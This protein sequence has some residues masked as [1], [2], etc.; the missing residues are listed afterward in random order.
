MSNEKLFRSCAAQ[1]AAQIIRHANTRKRT[2]PFHHVQTKLRV[3][4][5]VERTM[6]HLCIALA[7]GLAL[8]A[9]AIHA[10]VMATIGPVTAD[11]VGLPPQPPFITLLGMANPGK[12]VTDPSIPPK[13]AVRE[14]FHEELRAI[15][16][17][18]GPAG[19]VEASVRTKYDE[20]GRVIERI[21]NRFGNETDDVYRYQGDRVVGIETTCPDAKKPQ[22][23]AWNYWTWDS[24]GKLTEYRRGRGTEIQNHEVGFQY[25]SQGRLLGFDYK[26]GKNDQLFSHT[27]ISYSSDGKTV[28]VTQTFTGTKIV[29]RS[30]RTL[31]EKGRV[32]RVALDREGRAANNEASIILFQYDQQDRLVSQTTNAAG[33]SD[34]GAEQDLPPGT[35]SI[36]YDDKLHGKTTKYSFPGEGDMETFVTQDDG[37]ATTGFAMKA[38]SEQ[39]FSAIRCEY[40][41]QGNW[42]RCRQISQS[43]GPRI[44]KDFRRTITYR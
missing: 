18:A 24:R 14:V 11:S 43:D 34:S 38:A 4:L 7:I 22:P 17:P 40:D 8:S 36:A 33:F 26:Q 42:T 16:S 27:D 23:T 29:D 32:V 5:E 39:T 6:K 41:R 31:D 19:S 37:G 28:V 9:P 35:I 15:P 2:K 30:T 20:Q 3:E 1:V 13:G 25:D 21:E 10:Q 12:L 44:S